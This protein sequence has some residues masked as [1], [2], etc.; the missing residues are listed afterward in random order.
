MVLQ[1][2]LWMSVSHF[3]KAKFPEAPRFHCFRSFILQGGLFPVKFHG[4]LLGFPWQIFVGVQDS[5][6]LLSHKP[7]GGC[8]KL[9][10]YVLSGYCYIESFRKRRCFRIPKCIDKASLEWN[11]TRAT[12]YCKTPNDRDQLSNFEDHYNWTF[13][14]NF[15]KRSSCFI[16]TNSMQA[17]LNHLWWAQY[18]CQPGGVS[19]QYE[20]CL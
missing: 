7:Q 17:Y 5:F 4:A 1:T 3:W 18:L 15:F 11:C 16:F 2:V 8:D 6:V 19:L 9:I 13:F 12:T 20:N 10:G 14:L